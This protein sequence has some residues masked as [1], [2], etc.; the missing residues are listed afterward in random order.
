[1]SCESLDQ[2]PYESLST[3]SAFKSVENA[4]YWRNGFY[5]SLRN[6]SYGDIML[7]PDVQS[8]LL[9]ATLNYGNRRGFLQTWTFKT[10][11]SEISSIWSDRYSVLNDINKCIEEFPSIPTSSDQEKSILNKYLG[12]AY[13]LRAYYF[14]Q[15]VER[16]CPKYDTSN[17]SISNLGIPLVTAFDVTLLPPRATL[18]ESYN[19]IESDIAQAERLL[20]GDKGVKGSNY[21][22][23]DAVKALKARV[24]LVKGDY[25][26]A[27]TEAKN[28]VDEGKYPLV[29]TQEALRKVWHSD[30]TEETIVQLFSSRPDELPK[31]MGIYL[32]YQAKTKKYNPDYV[33]SKWVVD[34][35][36][37]SDF[38]KSIYFKDLAIETPTGKDYNATLVYKYPGNPDLYSG[39][40]IEYHSPKIFR[41]AELYLIASEAAYKN[42]DEANA[43]KYLNDLRQSRGLSAVNSSGNDLFKEIKEERLRELAFEG[44]RLNDLKRWG[45][46]VKRHSPQE[47]EYLVTNPK[48]QYYELEKQASDYRFTWPIPNHEM[49]IN[50]NLKQ[51]E[52]Y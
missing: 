52:G 37:A 28:I 32:S 30:A 4:E 35:Y 20:D 26:K 41:T 31:V 43:M 5:R 48:E 15:L 50:P 19:Q 18:E 14:F 6:V 17:K 3:N 38:R 13:A 46:G 44:T 40:P 47:T 16:F 8:D 45:E 27:Y 2:N 10:N 23:F 36:D 33:P 12:E 22:T 39:A 49:T 11:D 34:L 9:N 29:N 51:N 25:T 7:L 1:M 24:A 21:F 42:G